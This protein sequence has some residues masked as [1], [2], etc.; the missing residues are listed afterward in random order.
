MRRTVFSRS[1]LATACVAVV[2]FGGNALAATGSSDAAAPS[3]S[4]T[5]PEIPASVL[6]ASAAPVSTWTPGP[7][8]YGT[9]S[10][11]DVPVTAKDGTVLRVNVIYPTDPKT[12]AAAAGPFPVLLTQTPYGKG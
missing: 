10:Q 1:L 12:A 8:V 2:A 7:A 5:N 3:G 11:N 4:A 9:N 6:A